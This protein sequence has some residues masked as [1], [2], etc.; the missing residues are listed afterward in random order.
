[1]IFCISK[2][3]FKKINSYLRNQNLNY[4]FKSLMWVK[5]KAAVVL[6]GYPFATFCFLLKRASKKY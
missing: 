1:M 3:F 5:I 4:D 2:H 6:R